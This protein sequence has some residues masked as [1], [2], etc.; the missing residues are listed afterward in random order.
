MDAA[1]EVFYFITDKMI[2][3][4][5]YFLNVANTIAYII[6]TVSILT[7][8][9][10]Y[11]L[12][13]TGL[14]ENVVKIGKAFVFFSIA[15]FLYPR[16]ISWITD[17]TFTLAKESV[18]NGRL[19][20]EIQNTTYQMKD[21]AENIRVNNNNWTASAWILTEPKYNSGPRSILEGILNDRIITINGRSYAY[22][23]VAPAYALESVFLVAK[24]IFE[25]SKK[26]DY[27][28][29]FQIFGAL[30]CGFFTIVVGCFCVLEYLIA[31]VEFMFVS[32]VGVILFPLSLWD[33]TKFM[34]EKFIGAMLGFFVKLLFSAICIFLMLWAYITLANDYTQTP[35]LGEVERI[36]PLFFTSLLIF[37][38]CK[39]APALAQGLL[40]GTPNLSGAGAIGMVASTVMAASRL[41]HIGG[42]RS[43][44]LPSAQTSAAI[45][46]GSGASAIASQPPPQFFSVPQ[47]AP[48]FS[49]YALPAQQPYMAIEG[50]PSDLTMSLSYVNKPLIEGPRSGGA[51]ALPPPPNYPP[52]PN[53]RR[54]PGVAYEVIS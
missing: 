41:S 2:E 46:G 50:R 37:Y 18:Y 30:I 13:H 8:A 7:A 15:I 49:S 19:R 16:I 38:I 23:T 28:R 1:N 42:G 54:D 17:M 44:Q 40:S 21:A 39:S 9:I 4:Q 25:S 11:A 45:S 6:L 14:K 35:F 20:N 24:E 33:G 36:I 27:R 34:A 12:T 3:L 32:S 29:P 51:T 52:N 47:A 26:F 31:F 5:A 53:A 10:N 43:P 48:N 22:S